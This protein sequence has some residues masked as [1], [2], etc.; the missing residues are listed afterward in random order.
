MAFSDEDLKRLKEEIGDADYHEG[1]IKA[2]I[3][4]LEAAEACIDHRHAQDE[5]MDGKETDFLG[6]DE[7]AKVM[8]RLR[9]KNK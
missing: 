6:V 4:R 5:G 7:S 2:L 9:R 8:K 3:A 1:P